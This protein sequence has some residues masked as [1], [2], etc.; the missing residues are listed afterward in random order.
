VSLQVSW[1]RYTHKDA[2][3][4]I[5]KCHDLRVPVVLSLIDDGVEKNDTDALV[6]RHRASGL[7]IREKQ[8]EGL[9]I[10]R[11]GMTRWWM[12]PG[13]FLGACPVFSYGEF[14]RETP[15]YELINIDHFGRK[16]DFLGS[17]QLIAV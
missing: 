5:E 15:P 17:P 3:K 16:V 10:D 8:A 1:N 14:R 7:I 4:A 12:R 6:E 11:H 13:V 9:S 2:T